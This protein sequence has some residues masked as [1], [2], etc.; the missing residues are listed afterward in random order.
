VTA[1]GAVSILMPAVPMGDL[2]LL[3]GSTLLFAVVY[4]VVN[5]LLRTDGP[6]L[7]LSMIQQTLGRKE[8]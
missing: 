3:V 4:L 7:A 6:G 8:G 5:W 2:L 1:A